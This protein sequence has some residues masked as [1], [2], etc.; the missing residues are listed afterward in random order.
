MKWFCALTLASVMLADGCG[1]SKRQVSPAFPLSD[2]ARGPLSGDPW[3]FLTPGGIEAPHRPIGIV[4]THT[5]RREALETEGYAELR[6]KALEL[7]AD[8]VI[9]LQ[10]LP[11]FTE[12]VR[13]SPTALLRWGSEWETVYSLRG[14][15]VDRSQG[16]SGGDQSH[17][18]PL[19]P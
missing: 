15:A 7:G 9:E 3:V 10:I 18:G 5:Y 13:H 1:H 16:A 19:S 11:E 12:Q 6:A 8:A 4:Q 2:P 14:V 17:M